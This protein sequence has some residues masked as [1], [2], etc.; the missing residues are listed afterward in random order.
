MTYLFTLFLS[1][2]LLLA[3]P[4]NAGAAQDNAAANSLQTLATVSAELQE[5]TKDLR[6]NITHWQKITGDA[7]LSAAEKNQWQQKA[8]AYLQECLDY[9][10]LL[11]R[12]EVHKISDAAAAQRFV[13]ARRTFQRELL[14]F[15]D[16]LHKPQ[17]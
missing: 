17:E 15:Q 2:S 5:N 7:N 13:A 12:V 16:V 11:D 1:V 3:A 14:Y 8:A 4:A 9:S 10:A 6:R